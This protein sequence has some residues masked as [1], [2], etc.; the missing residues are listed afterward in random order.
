[1]V[2]IAKVMRRGA[3][4]RPEPGRKS[5]VFIICDIFLC[6]GVVCHS[7]MR[8]SGLKVAGNFFKGRRKSLVNRKPR[9]N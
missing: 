1:M 2:A 9:M 8:G 5:F 3:A 7:Y 6:L 4:A